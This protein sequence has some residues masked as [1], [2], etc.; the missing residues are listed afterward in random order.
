G[1]RIRAGTRDARPA[2]ADAV[3]RHPLADTEAGPGGRGNVVARNAG[4][5]AAQAGRATEARAEARARAA[6][7][8][9]AP[10]GA[11]TRTG[12]GRRETRHRPRAAAQGP[13]GG[14]APRGR[15][16]PAGR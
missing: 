6:T 14:R 5:A 4:R 7:P 15:G 10:R 2:R 3:R 9:P 11:Y 8:S 12:P 13:R 1:P 16:A